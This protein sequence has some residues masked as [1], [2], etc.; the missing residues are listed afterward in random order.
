[1]YLV[2]EGPAKELSVVF[3]D[4]PWG[5]ES[6]KD[7]QEVAVE[8]RQPVILPCLPPLFALPMK[9][10]ATENTDENL[11]KLNFMLLAAKNRT[12]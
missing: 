1:M 9:K 11:R 7:G 5:P 3:E 6:H 12:L 10:W 2:E 8:G 4:S